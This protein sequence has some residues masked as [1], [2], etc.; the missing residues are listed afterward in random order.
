MADRARWNTK[1]AKSLPIEKR[2]GAVERIIERIHRNMPTTAKVYV[3]PTPI[4]L[5]AREIP[6]DGILMRMIVPTKCVVKK[7]VFTVG[8]IIGGRTVQFCVERVRSGGVSIRNEFRIGD[9][10]KAV[11]TDIELYAGDMLLIT[12]VPGDGVNGPKGEDICAT[13]LVK[14][15]EFDLYSEAV[16]V[17]GM[18]EEL[19][20]IEDA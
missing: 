18:K 20:E 17:V 6:P 15:S 9:G 13:A 7:D 8:K 2:I 1:F 14:Y 16:E 3:P 12:G 4:S 11:D 19:L 5:Y 10:Y